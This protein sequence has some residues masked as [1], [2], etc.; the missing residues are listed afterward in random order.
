MAR[1]NLVFLYGQVQ[2]VPKIYANKSGELIRGIFSVKVLRRQHGEQNSNLYFDS[3]IIVSMNEDVIKKISKL[4]KGD[5]VA[6]KGV[7]TTKEVTKSASCDNC[8]TLNKYPGVSVFITPIHI[9]KCEN[10]LTEAEGITNLK[11]NNE[12]SNIAM[13]IGTLCREPE[14][15]E[16]FKTPCTQY[17]I[18]VNRKYHIK[19]DS[20]DTKTDYPWL[21]V[22]GKQ[23]ESD[24]AALHTNSTIYYSGSIQTRQVKRKMVCESCGAEYDYED[25]ATE[26][27]PYSV[28]YL[29]NC[30]LPEGKNSSVEEN[31]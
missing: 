11:E 21:K 28:E 23:A 5:M 22:Y 27:I 30:T 19:E 3:P 31:T 25:R 18:A 12:L 13:G 14:V 8:K 10:E 16:G 24:A 4:S 29:A 2:V 9:L 20:P 1:E 17:Q 6:I 26:I 15:I 7:L